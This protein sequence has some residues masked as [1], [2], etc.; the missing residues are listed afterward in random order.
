VVRFALLFQHR[1]QNYQWQN[2][3]PATRIGI[4]LGDATEFADSGSGQTK[5]AGQAV[6]LAARVM[7]LAGGGQI[8][9]TR[10]AFDSGRQYVHSH[11]AAREG[12]GTP[13]L[14]WL[15]HGR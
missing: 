4:H 1:L 7:G 3:R 10:A 2:E 15:A 8:L 11:P 5:M 13:E 6:D 12:S 14:Q 9:L